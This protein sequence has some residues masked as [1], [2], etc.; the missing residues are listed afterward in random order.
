MNDPLFIFK[1]C[2]SWNML[3]NV[4]S[5]HVQLYLL[6]FIISYIFILHAGETVSFPNEILKKRSLCTQ[7]KL[8]QVQKLATIT[9]TFHGSLRVNS[10]A[11]HRASF[12]FFIFLEVVSPAGKL[13]WQPRRLVWIGKLYVPDCVSPF[14]RSPCVLPIRGKVWSFHSLFVW[15]R[16]WAL[17]LSSIPTCRFAQFPD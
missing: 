17:W 6:A 1:N 2:W 5:K 13:V 3:Q 14:V 15:S 11:L 9:F 12:L 7:Q 4:R 10:A 8:F 16:I